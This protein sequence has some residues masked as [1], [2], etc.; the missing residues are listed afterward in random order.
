MA[1]A[2]L[3]ELDTAGSTASS[4]R[5]LVTRT[6]ARVS[7]IYTISV[8]W[9]GEAGHIRPPLYCTQRYLFKV[10]TL[11]DLSTLRVRL[12]PLIFDP[13]C[14]QT[15]TP[16][17]EKS[18]TRTSL[19]AQRISNSEDSSAAH[20]KPYIQLYST[21]AIAIVYP[22]SIKT[23]TPPPICRCTRV[24]R[25]SV[26]TPRRS[27]SHAK[28]VDGAATY[29]PPGCSMRERLHARACSSDARE[30]SSHCQGDSSLD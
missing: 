22:L 1:D 2:D 29:Q 30:G 17:I 12:Y 14:T 3:R 18:E 27:S 13:H 4:I 25:T 10:Y 5:A 28:T 16:E 15:A 20:T 24:G 21:S 6:R 26:G 7:S 9:Q 19:K 23:T 11:Y 8:S